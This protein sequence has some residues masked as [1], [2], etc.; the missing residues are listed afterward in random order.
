MSLKKPLIKDLLGQNRFR[1][2]ILNEDFDASKLIGLPE[3][4]LARMHP[5]DLAEKFEQLQTSEQINLLKIL[6]EHYAGLVLS[7]LQEEN[8]LP[9][10]RRMEA[11][12]L[13]RILSTMPADEAA[14]ILGE[15]Q[16][17]RVDRILAFLDEGLRN[18]T[19]ELL[20][21]EKDSAGG[22]MGKELVDFY[23][24]LSV[25]QALEI[26]RSKFDV[27]D[28]LTYLYVTNENQELIGVVTLK[29]LILSAPDVI[30]EEIMLKDVVRVYLE[31][32]QEKIAFLATK[33]N[34]QA[35]PVVNRSEQL[36]GIVA[37]DDISEIIEDEHEEDIYR[38]AGLHEEGGMQ[39]NPLRAALIRFPWL[40]ATVGGGLIAA[41]IIEWNQRIDFLWLLAFS[42][43]ILGLAGNVAIQ[44]STVII[45]NLSIHQFS[46]G[47][48]PTGL[49]RE[50]Q[51]GGILAVLCGFTLAILITIM[52]GN[53]TKGITLGLSLTAVIILS[54]ICSVLIPLGFNRFQIDPAIASGPLVTTFIDVCGLLV[55]FQC[56]YW[57]LK[58]LG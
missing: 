39:Q 53:G 7:R 27:S 22:G 19:I 49:F 33:Y 8:I 45:R 14:D 40:I 28:F 35:I 57:L 17:D 44:T 51:I 58:W 18:E 43:L 46:S 32:D 55:Y 56:A 9:V 36:V 41:Q 34:L 5:A 3:N 15:F 20:S 52:Q 26:L 16:E 2:R 25:S 12:H 37:P 4:E 29:R 6:P 1:F 11:E 54:N 24:D 31:E 21:H 23:S 42:P 50:V 10:T 30:L 47:P 13:S 48:S 38:M